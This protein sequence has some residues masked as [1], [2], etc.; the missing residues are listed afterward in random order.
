[1]SALDYITAGLAAF[2]AVAGGLA[3]LRLKGKA[4]PDADRMRAALERAREQQR[5]RQQ[6]GKDL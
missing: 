4:P 5:M 2:G 6:S 1:M 3:L